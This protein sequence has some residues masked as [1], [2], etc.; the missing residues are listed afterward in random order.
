[1]K[2]LMFNTFL[3]A[4]QMETDFWVLKILKLNWKKKAEHFF[5]K[6]DTQNLY[7]YAGLVVYT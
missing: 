6:T 4:P 7:I 3:A 2:T 5:F 1:M